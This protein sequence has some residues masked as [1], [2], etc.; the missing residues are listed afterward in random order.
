MVFFEAE[1][2]ADGATTTEAV[3]QNEFLARSN[4]LF[5]MKI[6]K[7]FVLLSVWLVEA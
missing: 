2:P 1:M 6:L 3:K 7:S 5:T 4:N